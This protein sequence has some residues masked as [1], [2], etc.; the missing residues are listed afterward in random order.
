VFMRFSQYAVRGVVAPRKP[1]RVAGG[2]PKCRPKSVLHRKT[3]AERELRSEVRHLVVTGVR[4]VGGFWVG[5][6]PA[7][8]FATP[9]ISTRMTTAVISPPQ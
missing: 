2:M 5:Q 1:A 7:K 9:Q 3:E 8:Y 6:A 4:A